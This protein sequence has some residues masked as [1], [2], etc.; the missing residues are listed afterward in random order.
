[1]VYLFA[2]QMIGL[3]ANKIASKS[4]LSVVCEITA[5]QIRKLEATCLLAVAYSSLSLISPSPSA[6]CHVCM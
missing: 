3:E 5:D 2:D 6:R 4:R 1:M